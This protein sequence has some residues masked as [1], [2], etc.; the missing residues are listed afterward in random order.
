MEIN[1]NNLMHVKQK[2]EDI[3]ISFKKIHQNF[4]NVIEDSDCIDTEKIDTYYSYLKEYEAIL[5]ILNS[6][7]SMLNA[8]NKRIESCFSQTKVLKKKRLTKLNSKINTEEEDDEYLDLP[9]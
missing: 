8:E 4:L 9:F 7:F 3:Y 5:E 2:I 6:N 1:Y